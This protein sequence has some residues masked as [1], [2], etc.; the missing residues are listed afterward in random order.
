MVDVKPS[1]SQSD[2]NFSDAR[3]NFIPGL[4]RAEAKPNEKRSL[5]ALPCLMMPIGAAQEA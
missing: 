5:T 4:R 2:L 3:R 1:E